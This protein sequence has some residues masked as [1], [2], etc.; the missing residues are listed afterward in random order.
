MK[1]I[2]VLFIISLMFFISPITHANAELITIESGNFWKYSRQLEDGWTNV[3]FDDSYWGQ[4]I[5]PSHGLCNPTPN[6]G[7]FANPMWAPNPV[8]KETVY[9][10]RKFFLD[11]QPES[12]TI[13]VNF[14]DDGDVYINGNLIWSDR[15]G[16]VNQIPFQG[17]ISEFLHKGENVVA[18]MAKDSYGGCQA[19]VAML[20]IIIALDEGFQLNV[21]LFK[22]ND[23]LWGMNIYDHADKQKLMC[24]V[25]MADCGCLTTS[26]AMLF[27]YHGITR[28]PDGSI[29]S[30]E[31]LNIFF[32]SNA[33]CSKFGCI[34]LGYA[35]GSVRWGVVNNYSKASHDTYGTP[36]II[37]RGIQEY[38]ENIIKE[39]IHA[40]N[41]VILRSVIQDRPHWFVIK[42]IRDQDFL[43]NDPFYPREVIGQEMDDDVSEK[44]ARFAKTNSDFSILEIFIPLSGHVLVTDSEGRRTGFD[45]QNGIVISEIPQS[46]YEFE[47]KE[48]IHKLLIL[49][50]NSGEYKVQVIPQEKEFSFAMYG[51]NRDARTIYDFYE[52]QAVGHN[53]PTYIFTYNP[54]GEEDAL[55]LKSK[56]N[57][58]SLKVKR[59]CSN[60]YK[61]KIKCRGGR[62]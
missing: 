46:L 56:K 18:L 10:R 22:Q 60:K 44:I 59:N 34:S 2:F 50:P 48:G 37:F 54:D 5:S 39:D 31:N 43:I 6:S 19:A 1:Y 30:P 61:N 42:G 4:T 16:K 49:T 8:E 26:L 12:G 13:K 23:P 52:G 27:Q 3:D 35:Y 41:P 21:P 20:E 29:T 17:D 24:G 62:T 32:K 47:E 15:S 38:N 9:F 58:R 40:S 57:V 53:I 45:L 36:K 25:T 28:G 7:D 51:S 55:H 14:D 11:K 33:K